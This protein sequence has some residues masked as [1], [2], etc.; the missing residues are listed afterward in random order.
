MQNPGA[1]FVNHFTIPNLSPLN[2]SGE[3]GRE[4]WP[5][6]EWVGECNAGT[7]GGRGKAGRAEVIHVGRAH[8]ESNLSTLGSAKENVALIY[9]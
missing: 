4:V 9:S 6:G 3:S 1:I 5:V 8:R 7:K 2:H